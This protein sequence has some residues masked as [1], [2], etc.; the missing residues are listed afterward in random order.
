M[1][2]L[3]LEPLGIAVQADPRA[4]RIAGRGNHAP[5]LAVGG[6]KAAWGRKPRRCCSPPPATTMSGATI[7]PALRRRQMGHLRPLHRF[8]PRLSGRRS[9]QVDQRFI[10]ALERVSIGDLYPDLTFVLDVPAELGLR[11]AAGRRR[12]VPSP[13][14]SRRRTSIFT[15]S[16]AKPICALAAAE[17]ERCVIVDAERAEEGGRQ[18][19][20]GG[21]E[22]AGSNQ[23]TAPV[24]HREVSARM[25]MSRRPK[26]EDSDAPQPR[27]TDVLFGH[28]ATEPALLAAYRSG[29][30]PH[31]FLLVGQRASARRRSLTGMA[32]FVLAH[33]D[34]AAPAVQ[35]ATSLAVD[36][37]A[38]GRAPH[39]RAGPRRSARARAHAE[40]QGRAAP[41]DRGRGRPPHGRV[42]RLDGRGGGLARSPSSTRSTNSTAPAPT[43][44]SRCWRSRRER[45]LLLLVCHSA[46]RVLPTM[47]SRCRVVTLRPLAQTDVAAALAAATGRPASDPQIAAAA[48][49]ADGSVARALAFARRATR[50]RCASS[51]LDC[52]TGCRRSMPT[53]C[54]RSA[55]P[56]PAPIRSR[57][58]PSSTPSMPGCRAGSTA[59]AE[60]DWPAGAAGRGRGSASI[61]PARDVETTIS[62]ESHWF[63][64]S[65][66]CLPRPRAVD[67]YPHVSATRFPQHGRQALLHHHRDLLPERR[68]AYRPRLRGDRHRRD[69][70]LH[71]ARRLRRVLPHRHR[72]ARHQ[73][74]ADGGQGEPDA[75]RNSSTATCRASRPW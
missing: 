12:G 37:D 2:A 54:M 57:S 26:R 44:S 71:A 8:H 41:A 60:R 50:W 49:A 70:A 55:T 5:R 36:P 53:R 31:A 30:M 43:R 33:P 7:L 67:T 56:R 48:A 39:R 47:R 73:D 42:F 35:A 59:R 6:G 52:S 46:A 25:S 32:R 61:R 62:S 45:A 21:R 23:P 58:P 20:L 34:P 22:F 1:L 11:R 51:A 28:A 72:R 19:H 69:R 27:E 75:A 64:A 66:A 14:A 40:R 38:S 68:A 10:R 24:D 4:G 18:A 17:P 15:K 74:A 3:R 29:R 65:S 63:S 9:A 13:I 16:C